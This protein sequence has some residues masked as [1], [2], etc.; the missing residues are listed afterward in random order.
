MR[1]SVLTILASLVLLFSAEAEAAPPQG[2]N[3]YAFGRAY[4]SGEQLR[5]FVWPRWGGGFDLGVRALGHF[6]SASSLNTP[7]GGLFITTGYHYWYEHLLDIHGNLGYSLSN[8]TFMFGVGSKINLLEFIEDPTGEV[9]AKGIQRGL[10]SRL[11][12][13][14]MIFGQID[15]VHY[16]FPDSDTGQQLTYDT[17]LWSLQYGFGVQWYFY[18]KN[19]FA[20]RFYLETSISYSRFQQ[21]HYMLPYFGIGF[22]VQ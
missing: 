12:Q 15:F 4:R 2:N 7:P 9:F 13:N 11:L 3:P 14:F 5:A 21:N 19:S 18:I 10:L 8:G 20:R 6:G 1:A 16:N 17:S 22:E